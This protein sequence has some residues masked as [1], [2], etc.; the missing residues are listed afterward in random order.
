M[1]RPGGNSRIECVLQGVL[2]ACAAVWNGL[3]VPL[4]LQGRGEG[5]AAGGPPSQPHR[6]L[7]RVWPRGTWTCEGLSSSKS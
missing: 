6:V 1:Q 4:S 5:R 7:S 2:A 3:N